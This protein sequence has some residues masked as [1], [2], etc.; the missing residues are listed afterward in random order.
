[1]PAPLNYAA[2]D[3]APPRVSLLARLLC[4][5]VFAACPPIAAVVIRVIYYYGGFDVSYVW[6]PLVLPIA[7]AALSVIAVRRIRRSRGALVGIPF[8]RFALILSLVWVVV[9]LVAMC[10]PGVH[11]E[12][13]R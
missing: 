2:V 11:R 5:L 8:A 7:V 9:W 12:L 10:S 1:M 6:L 3:P 13:G 4:V